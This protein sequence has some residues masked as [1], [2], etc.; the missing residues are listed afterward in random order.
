MI[1]YGFDE[2]KIK[3]RG[4]GEN[5]PI[6]ENSADGYSKVNR[7]VEFNIIEE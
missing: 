5:I 2:N 7:R 1:N 6:V 3:A 4:Y